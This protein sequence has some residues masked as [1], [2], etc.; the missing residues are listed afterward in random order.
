MNDQCL[1]A[2]KRYLDSAGA[3]E[4]LHLGVPETDSKQLTRPSARSARKAEQEESSRQVLV[5][6]L[7]KILQ[8]SRRMVNIILVAYGLMFLVVF[9][10]LL[11]SPT[12]W[13]SPLGA[14]ALFTGAMTV[15]RSLRG[16]WTTAILM[17]S[18]LIMA[19]G[20]PE[21]TMVRVLSTMYY[22]ELNRRSNTARPTKSTLGD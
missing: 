16:I 20:L 18:I 21:E 17:E 1:E 15:L 2:L 3:L 5:E 9:A 13:S 19:P 8:S 4:D 12:P 6:R 22:G 11:L 7:S 10:A 14:A